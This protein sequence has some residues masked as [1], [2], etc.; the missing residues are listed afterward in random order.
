MEITWIIGSLIGLA[1]LW[2]YFRRKG[3][4]K[5]IR[6]RHPLFPLLLIGLL[7]I[8]MSGCNEWGKSSKGTETAQGKTNRSMMEEEWKVIGIHQDD[9]NLT[10]EEKE[11]EKAAKAYFKKRYGIDV[12]LYEIYR[13]NMGGN[14]TNVYLVDDPEFIISVNYAKDNDNT[15][16]LYQDTY[17]Y[18]R[19]NY[20]AK[21]K[22]VPMIKELFSD[23]MPVNIKLWV[24]TS[25]QATGEYGR[26]YDGEPLPDIDELRKQFP[27]YGESIRIS[28]IKNLDHD[29]EKE[30][31]E[32]ERIFKLVQF[33]RDRKIGFDLYIAY[34]DEVIREK[35]ET[36]SFLKSFLEEP[37]ATAFDTMPSN[38]FFKYRRAVF[39]IDYYPYRPEDQRT[40]QVEQ[41]KT[42]ED[43]LEQKFGYYG[44]N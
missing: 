13:Y 32:A 10:Q 12:A 3:R 11:L 33:Y 18:D 35:G 40:I 26:N 15:Y 21:K 2:I 30:L 6:F 23:V 8:G 4:Q 31:K 20:L 22:R 44:E 14:G 37:D 5:E 25:G 43:L 42:P 38:P 24:T 7:M 1:G 9:S 17:F 36:E 41:L 29:R 39:G 34:Y 27:K 16:V 28:V 19:L